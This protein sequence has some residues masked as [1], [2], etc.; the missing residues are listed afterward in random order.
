MGVICVRL[1]DQIILHRLDRVR[2][3]L[4]DSQLDALV[5]YSAPTDL[6]A[7]TATSGNVRYLTD[8]AGKLR[9]SVL[10]IAADGRTTLLV[11]SSTDDREV[12][13]RPGLVDEVRVVESHWACGKAAGEILRGLPASPTRVGFAGRREMPNG[14]ADGLF[15][16]WPREAVRDVDRLLD[17]HRIVKE[18]E[19]IELQR[20]GSR[21]SDAMFRAAMDGAQHVGT[22]ASQIGVDMECAGRSLGADLAQYWLMVGPAPDAHDEGL[23]SFNDVWQS[24][25]ELSPGDRLVASTYVV[26][27]GYW[28][29]GMRMAVKGPPTVDVRRHYDRLLEVQDAGLRALTPGRP[30]H[31]AA[32]AMEDLIAECSPL[33]KSED[34]FRF[35][36]GHGLGLQYAEPMVSDEFTTSPGHPEAECHKITA[37]MILEIHPNFTVPGIG[38]FCVGD[39][40]LVTPTGAELLTSFPRELYEV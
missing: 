29:H 39:T 19:V 9:S 4:I 14:I 32:E 36:T 37:G 7:S 10:I 13:K 26:Y 11:Y 16:V 6:G 38:F 5:A 28:A 8:W 2:S 21:I 31:E 22:T 33:A 1:P 3:S 24:R 40:V 34:V 30:L 18:P 17:V 12:R 27:R 20:E 25:T 35:R 15:E 23:A